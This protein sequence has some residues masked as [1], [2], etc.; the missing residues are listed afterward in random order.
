MA[1]E[2]Y[3]SLKANY[4][5]ML[6]I[7]LVSLSPFQY[8]I[9]FGLIGGIQAMIVRCFQTDSAESMAD[10]IERSQPF[11]EIF[12]YKDPKSAVGYN[13]SPTFQQLIGS[14]MTLGAFIASGL[15]GPLAQ[16]LG[17]KSCLWIACV[18]CCVSDAI[19]MGSTSVGGLYLARLLIGLSN[20]QTSIHDVTEL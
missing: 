2:D 14:L 7:V 3:E 5:C 10:Y 16:I 9:D 19:M 13:I 20:G 15:S 4:K 1:G 11:M 6:A 17:R 8:G 12:G 18:M